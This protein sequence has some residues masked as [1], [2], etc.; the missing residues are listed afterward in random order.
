MNWEAY[1]KIAFIDMLKV[2]LAQSD[3]N[4]MDAANM[5]GGAYQC[6]QDGIPMDLP[7]ALEDFIK[8]TMCGGAKPPWYET[9]IG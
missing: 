8:W 2:Y 4:P 9:C 6:R 5:V 3:V 7:V 1:N